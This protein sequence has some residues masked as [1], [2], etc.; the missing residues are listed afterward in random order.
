MQHGPEPELIE[1]PLGRTIE[2]NGIRLTI[3]IVRIATHPGWSLEVV[4]ENGTSIV[5]DDPFPTDRAADAAFC[6]ALAEE[7]PEAFLDDR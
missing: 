4:N 6:K 3:N 5:W 1:S 7:G 2:Q